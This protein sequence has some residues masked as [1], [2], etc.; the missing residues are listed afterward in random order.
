MLSR[1]CLAFAI[2]YV[3]GAFAHSKATIELT[4]SVTESTLS[5]RAKR[6]LR[7]QGHQTIGDVA[8]FFLSSYFMA[9]NSD[10]VIAFLREHHLRVGMTDHEIREFNRSGVTPAIGPASSVRSLDLHHKIIR[11]LECYDIRTIG[12]LIQYSSGSLRDL[13]FIGV[14]TVNRI[15]RALKENGLALAKNEKSCKRWL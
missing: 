11:T 14:Q 15:K 5:D 13:P 3:T 7:L 6:L 10:E 9:E 1:L 8:R 2:I 4:T 12:D